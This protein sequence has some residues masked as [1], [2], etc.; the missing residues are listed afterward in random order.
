MTKAIVSTVIIQ[1][2]M[3][4]TFVFIICHCKWFSFC[5]ILHFSS[6][7]GKTGWHKLCITCQGISGNCRDFIYFVWQ[8]QVIYRTELLR[9][10]GPTVDPLMNGPVCTVVP[11]LWF[12]MG[13]YEIC[14]ST[15]AGFSPQFSFIY[16]HYKMNY[17][18]ILCVIQ[19]ALSDHSVPLLVSSYWSAAYI[20][21]YMC[22]CV[23]VCV[24]VCV[25]DGHTLFILL[26]D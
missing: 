8:Y 26:Q 16:I 18:C 11:K 19:L 15:Y 10:S 25:V 24:Y 21:I 6:H 20:Y 4:Y 22:V 5:K 23:C 14:T 1:S 7:M 9:I 12:T 13:I 3:C 2:D 17:V